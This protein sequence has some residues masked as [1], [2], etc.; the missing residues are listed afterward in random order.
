MCVC[1]CVCVWVC[2][3]VRVCVLYKLVT[4]GVCMCEP[5]CIT[6]KDPSQVSSLIT[7]CICLFILRYG[8]TLLMVLAVYMLA[9][10]SQR[11][12]PPLPPQC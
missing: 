9:L 8:L 4:V 1:V 10:N 7:L 3:C 12:P 6:A 2:V 5:M 11:F